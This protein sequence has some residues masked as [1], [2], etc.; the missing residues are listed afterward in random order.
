M[1]SENDVS[2]VPCIQMDA[3]SAAPN[4][5]A[6][7]GVLMSPAASR[8]PNRFW[9]SFPRTRASATATAINPTNQYEAPFPAVPGIQWSWPLRQARAAGREYPTARCEVPGDAGSGGSRSGGAEGRA[10]RPPNRQRLDVADWFV[11][12]TRREQRV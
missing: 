8:D 2:R 10:C 5:A 1:G 3:T 4:V 9:Y 12:V 7:S 6:I 11:P